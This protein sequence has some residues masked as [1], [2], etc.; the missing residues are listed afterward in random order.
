MYQGKIAFID[1]TTGNVKKQEIPLEWRH[2]YMGSRGINEYLIFSMLKPPYD[3]LSPDN[4]LIFGIGPLTGSLGFGTG[5]TVV[6]AQSPDTGNLGDSNFGGYFGPEMKYAGF[7]HLVITG[8]SDHPVYLF[9][10]NGDI[11]IKDARHLWGKDTWET[12]N[13]IKRDNNDEYVRAAVIGP[14]GENV[15]RFAS[16]LTEYKDAAGRYGMGAVMGSKNLKAVAV[17]GTTRDIALAHPKELLSYMEEQIQILLK[18]GWIKAIRRL[19]TPLL[20]TPAVEGGWLLTRNDEV[21]PPMEDRQRLVGDNLLPYSPGMAACGGCAVHCRHR[22]EVKEGRYK[23]IGHG[24]EYGALADLAYNPEILD[25]EY[26]MY[27]NDLCNRLGLDVMGTGIMT[28]FAMEL[29][30]REILTR[31]DMPEPLVWGDAEGTLSMME[32]IAHRRGLGDTLADGVYSLKRLPPE[33]DYYLL[34]MRNGMVAAIGG[35]VVKSFTF[36]QAVATIGGHP[37]RSRAG[38]DVLRLPPEVLEKLCGGPI[39]SSYTSYDGKALLVWWHELLYAVC[40]SIGCCRFQTVLN[41]PTAPKYEEYAQLLKLSADWDVSVEELREI[42]ERIYTT[43]RLTLGRLGWGSREH[44]TI[45]DKWLDEPVPEGPMQGEHIDRQKF[46][47]FLDAY[48]RFHGWD[49]N[50]HPTPETVERLKIQPAS[51]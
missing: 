5:R 18:K 26:L 37:H 12:Q 48:Y 4:P 1:L 24:P 29:F 17:R 38:V 15:V 3:P 2:K 46:Q 51:I 36:S 47:E 39:A 45:P 32:D 6:A 40:D 28:T 10:K 7:D 16:I 8:K 41:S 34:R 33:A 27:A 50:G 31:Q 22:H 35:R 25:V 9:I 42:G 44:D 11:Q 13:A 23:T 19:G 21:L 20:F 30:Q 43:E 49:S 14:A